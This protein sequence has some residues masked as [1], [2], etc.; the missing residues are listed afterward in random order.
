MHLCIFDIHRGQKVSLIKEGYDRLSGFHVEIKT[1]RDL[2]F[3]CPLFVW[4]LGKGW[5]KISETLQPQKLL[6]LE[7]LQRQP[8]S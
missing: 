8:V 1:F 2:R 7:D 5:N 4:H 6:D 3:K